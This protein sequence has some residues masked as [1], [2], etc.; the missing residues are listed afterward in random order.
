VIPGGGT[1]TGAEPTTSPPAPP[2]S[3]A[4]ALP[5]ITV[6]T[7][8]EDALGVSWIRV[9][10]GQ[11]SAL[12]PSQKD[13]WYIQ[14]VNVADEN[15]PTPTLLHLANIDATSLVTINT[16]NGDVYWLISHDGRFDE[17]QMRLDVGG[18]V[19]VV[20]RDVLRE[21]YG[22]LASI[23]LYIL[24]SIVITPPPATATPAPSTP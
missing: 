9:A 23:P 7:P 2:T 11:M 20:D 17:V 16:R 12:M 18:E 13:G 8:V 10:V 5:P 19:R 24:D 4:T 3:T 14:G 6:G 21:A 22:D 15:I 1:P